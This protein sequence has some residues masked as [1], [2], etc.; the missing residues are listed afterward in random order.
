MNKTKIIDV[1]GITVTVTRKTIKNW[2][3]RACPQQRNIQMSVP[4]LMPEGA[5]LQA[6]HSQFNWILKQRQALL[7]QPIR[8]ELK[9]L[10]GEQHYFQGQAYPLKIIEHT[11]RNKVLFRDNSIALYVPSQ[12]DITMREKIL[13]R[14]YR[15][16]LQDIVPAIIEK[17][18]A[19]IGVQIQDWRNKKMKTRWGTCN[20][21]DKRIWLNLELIKKPLVCL[22]YI[23]VHEL[24]HLLERN[25]NRRFYAHMDRFLPDWR[26]LKKALE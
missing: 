6:I 2:Y 22:E 20:T 10:E 9:I 4:R 13:H 1:N 25:H 24:V 8:P 3:L 14:W 12:S 23:V 21:A 11:G 16:Q 5:I 26:G 7:S 18:Q 19:I 17:W 15:E